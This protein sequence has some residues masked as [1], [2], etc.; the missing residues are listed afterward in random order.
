MKLTEKKESKCRVTYSGIRGNMN[1]GHWDLSIHKRDIT[2][3]FY[4]GVSGIR[5][6]WESKAAQDMK[7]KDKNFIPTFDH[8]L[9]PQ[10]TAYFICDNWRSEEHTS[11][12]QSQD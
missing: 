3:I 5:T 12:L 9:A 6:G 1:D 11:E 7:M 8:V 10:T 4:E 2:R